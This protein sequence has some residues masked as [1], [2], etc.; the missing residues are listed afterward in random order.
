MVAAMAEVT[1]IEPILDNIRYKMFIY[2][3]ILCICILYF[4]K[5]QLFHLILEFSVKIQAHR[6]KLLNHH[7]PW[8]IEQAKAARLFIAY[9]WE[10]HWGKTLPELHEELGITSF[11]QSNQYQT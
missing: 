4:K 7:L 8:V 10:N 2:A 1:A 5:L 3:L 11:F 9:D 6:H